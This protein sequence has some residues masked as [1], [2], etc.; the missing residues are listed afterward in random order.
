MV[1]NGVTFLLVTQEQVFR[2]GCHGGGGQFRAAE[3]QVAIPALKSGFLATVDVRAFKALPHMGGGEVVQPVCHA[4]G[5]R[6]T[7]YAFAVRVKEYDFN[8]AQVPA[9]QQ[10]MDV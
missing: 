9:Y 5:V 2:N 6:A 7:A 4:E 3:Q 10:V 8:I 1:V